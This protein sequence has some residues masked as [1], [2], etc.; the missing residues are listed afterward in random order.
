MPSK[1]DGKTRQRSQARKTQ[2]SKPSR[3]GTSK[4]R[5]K[6]EAGIAFSLNKRGLGFDY[7]TQ[8]YD[9]TIEAIYTPDFILPT[10]VVEAKGVLTTEDRRKLR[11]VKQSHP[12]LDLRLCFQNAKAKLSKAPRSLRYWQW[13]ERHG[14]PWCE[15]HIPTA[16]FNDAAS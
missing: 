2:R 13:A 4:F 8:H 7:E 14:F 15:G 16:W 10:C 12:D 6:F 11:S 5:S 3:S 9:Y 1:V